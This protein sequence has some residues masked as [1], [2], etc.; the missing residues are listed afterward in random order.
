MNEKERATIIERVQY[1]LRQGGHGDYAVAVANICA[2]SGIA[3]MMD[4]A[5]SRG[6]AQKS[7][8]N[9]QKTVTD[10]VAW[11]VL[12]EGS[13][14]LLHVQHMKP[15]NPEPGVTYEPLY[16]AQPEGY[17]GI[18]HDYE[19]MRLALIDLEQAALKLAQIW[20]LMGTKE[21]ANTA[22]V[23]KRRQDVDKARAQAREA[24]K[25]KPG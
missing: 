1:I 4:D 23:N 19:M 14:E 24:I 17:P 25:R 21:G 3:M 22:E 7:G 2:P 20:N 5:P 6:Y 8:S 16:Y 13:E 9:V 12:D 10:P 15:E 11:A 18:A